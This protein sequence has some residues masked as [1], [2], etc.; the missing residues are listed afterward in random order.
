ML[1]YNH[2]LSPQISPLNILNAFSQLDAFSKS[3]LTTILYIKAST[4]FVFLHIGAICR[5]EIKM[6]ASDSEEKF[7]FSKSQ[8]IPSVFFI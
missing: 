1:C 7:I 4:L 5:P 3:I 8:P 6:V 2:L